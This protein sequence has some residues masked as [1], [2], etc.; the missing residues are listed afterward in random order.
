MAFEVSSRDEGNAAREQM[1]DTNWAQMHSEERIRLCDSCFADYLAYN[2]PNQRR[3]LGCRERGFLISFGDIAIVIFTKRTKGQ[4]SW[5]SNHTPELQQS[6]VFSHVK[7]GNFARAD[8]DDRHVPES[9][10]EG[11]VGFP[12]REKVWRDH[13]AGPHKQSDGHRRPTLAPHPE[14]VDESPTSDEQKGNTRPR[15]SQNAAPTPQRG[16]DRSP[17]SRVSLD[18]DPSRPK[19]SKERKQTRN[20]PYGR[21]GRQCA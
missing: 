20:R 8:S 2:E 15:I 18:S 1:R 3:E 13:G 11:E 4:V 10:I 17:R 9:A 16:R 14:E 19:Y 12:H 6:D 7:S 21:F 5:H